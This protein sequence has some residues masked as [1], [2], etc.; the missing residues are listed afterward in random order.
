MRAR[1]SIRTTE[2]TRY[3]VILRHGDAINILGYTARRS[4][5]GLEPYI[6]ANVDRMLAIVGEGCPVRRERAGFT[7]GALRVEFSGRT[8]REAAL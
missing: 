7:I 3:E 2:P 5:R 4:T 1:T 6:T 8:E